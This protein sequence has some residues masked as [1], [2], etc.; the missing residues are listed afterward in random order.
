MYGLR[1]EGENKNTVET[2]AATGAK[3]ALVIGLFKLCWF[4]FSNVFVVFKFCAN[5]CI[6]F[7]LCKKKMNCFMVMRLIC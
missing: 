3:K 1:R 5:Y 4:I 6:N 2:K 7:Y